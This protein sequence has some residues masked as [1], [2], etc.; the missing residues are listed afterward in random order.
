MPTAPSDLST[1][2]NA[3]STG[4]YSTA[5]AIAPNTSQLYGAFSFTE[6][7]TARSHAPTVHSPTHHAQQL[8]PALDMHAGLTQAGPPHRDADFHPS[9]YPCSAPA[10]L[11][12]TQLRNIHPSPFT[13]HMHC[14]GHSHVFSAASDFAACA[15][16][17]P[18]SMLSATQSMPSM[19]QQ[20]HDI[21]RLSEL[22]AAAALGSAKAQYEIACMV[23]EGRGVPPDV[24]FATAW[25]GCAASPS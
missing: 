14:Y 6:Q 9:P 5:T 23:L 2:S 7:L 3:H 4:P 12:A 22:E 19:E 15:G 11:D 8:V 21:D 18:R 16:G 25:F 24:R 13:S 10:S 20:A 1:Y 17:S